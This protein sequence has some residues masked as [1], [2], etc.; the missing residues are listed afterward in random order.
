MI[1]DPFDYE[2]YKPYNA[3]LL[4]KKTKTPFTKRIKDLMDC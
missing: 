2:S 4:G 3:C 1:L